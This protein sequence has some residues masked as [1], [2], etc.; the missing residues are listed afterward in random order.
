LQSYRETSAFA[1]FMWWVSFV[2][3]SKILKSV[4]ARGRSSALHWWG[5]ART[6]GEDSPEKAFLSSPGKRR[7]NP[8]GGRC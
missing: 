4:P 5:N 1:R 2:A 3:S 6:G 7:P 8:L